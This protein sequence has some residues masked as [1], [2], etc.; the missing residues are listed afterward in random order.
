MTE[1]EKTLLKLMEIMY[2]KSVDYQQL[3][4]PKKPVI[5][6][7]DWLK[8]HNSH[9]ASILTVQNEKSIHNV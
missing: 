1:Q 9:L 3:L 4:E 7:T 5:P 8:A 6:Y 2:K